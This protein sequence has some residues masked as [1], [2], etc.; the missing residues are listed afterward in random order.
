MQ[1]TSLITG[2]DYAPTPYF[3]VY[4]KQMLAGTLPRYEPLKQADPEM[5]H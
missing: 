2:W 5:A 4:V 3:G 1:T